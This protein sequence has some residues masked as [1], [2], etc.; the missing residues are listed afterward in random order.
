MSRKAAES[1]TNKFARRNGGYKYILH[2]IN[3][4]EVISTEKKSQQKYSTS[5]KLGIEVYMYK[6][7][8]SR[9]PT[10]HAGDMG[11]MPGQADEGFHSNQNKKFWEDL[12]TYFSLIRHRAH[13]KLKSKGDTQTRWQQGDQKPPNRDTQTDKM[14][15]K[16]PFIF[17]K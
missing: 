2:D 11:S 15:S 5:H 14:I 3:T 16:A 4:G 10:F 1:S 9:F 13:R 17:S 6:P 7:P 12:I 8:L